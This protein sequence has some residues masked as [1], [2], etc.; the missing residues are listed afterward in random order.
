MPLSPASPTYAKKGNK[1]QKQQYT[2]PPPPNN[3]TWAPCDRTEVRVTPGCLSLLETRESSHT[4]VCSCWRLSHLFPSDTLESP[5]RNYL[6]NHLQ[7]L[8]GIWPASF[9]P[10][11]SDFPTL[12]TNHRSSS[13]NETLGLGGVTFFIIQGLTN[14][15]EKKIIL[16][17]ILL[18]IYIMV[19]GGNSIIIYVALTDPKL[20][21]PLYF[22]LCNLSFVDMV[23]TTTT[24]PNMLSGLLTDILTISVLGCFL[25]MYF[26]IQLSVTGRAILTVMA[27][28]R[29]VAICNPLQYNSIMTRPVRLLL[30]AGAWGFGAICTLPVTVIAFER[31]YC[32]PNVVKHAWCDP[33]SVRR[34]VCSDTSLDNIVSL[35]FA[36]VSLVTTGVFILSSYILIGFSISRMVVA[37]R[38]KALRTCSAHLTVVSISYAAASFV[39]ISYR[40]G[41]FSSEVRII[42]SVLY[43]ALTPFLNPMIYSLRNKELRESI[44]R[45]LSRFRPAAVLPTKKISTLS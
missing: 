41:N 23:Y 26:F 9:C 21:S 22:F 18:L 24:I 15:D 4:T 40:V 6:L 32:G 42:V 29:Y 12:S 43:S 37:Q 20:N 35:L 38:L 28:D 13:V 1:T 31:P 10:A 16:F 33:S 14:L 30:V 19:L 8:H 34:L 44:R 17:S 7:L 2:Y 3:R 5:S 36:M 45:T 11:L 39:Y 25:Q 27:Y